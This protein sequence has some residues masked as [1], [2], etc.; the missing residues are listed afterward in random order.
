M[1]PFFRLKHS[2][3][4]PYPNHRFPFCLFGMGSFVACLFAIFFRTTSL[5]ANFLL[6]LSIFFLVLVCHS[7]N[8]N[9]VQPTPHHPQ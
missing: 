4:L 2:E 7:F 9:L 6:M 3:L 5:L 8:F 1:A